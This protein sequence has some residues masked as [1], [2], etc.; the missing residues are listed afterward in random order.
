MD[1][2]FGEE[3]H[4]IS[5]EEMSVHTHDS[6]FA[7]YRFSA[8]AGATQASKHNSMTAGFP[9][10]PGR[11]SDNPNEVV[12]CGKAQKLTLQQKGGGKLFDKTQ[13][14]LVLRFIVKY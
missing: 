3:H 5:L 11:S 8:D 9:Y 4:Q 13:P 7:V 14:S 1:Q 10:Y 2:L 12:A 6:K